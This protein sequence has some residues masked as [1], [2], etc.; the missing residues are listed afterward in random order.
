MPPKVHKKWLE[1]WA[2]PADRD[3]KIRE[4]EAE[5]EA[6]IVKS[7]GR[8][9]SIEQTDRVKLQ[10]SSRMVEIVEELA[11]TLPEMQNAAVASSFLELVRELARHIGRD[12]TAE[13]TGRWYR[14]SMSSADI[15]RLMELQ[16]SSGGISLM[17][18]RVIEG[19]VDATQGAGEAQE[20]E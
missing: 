5:R 13:E 6:T 12:E 3:L 18:P 2:A 7:E 14:R 16:S 15:Q 19:E 8:A 20:N 17:A 9:R 10:S 4:A 1:R 11:K